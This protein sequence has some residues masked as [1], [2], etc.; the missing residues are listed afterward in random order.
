MV[1]PTTTF[2][3]LSFRGGRVVQECFSQP[4]VVLCAHLRWALGFWKPWMSE[5]VRAVGVSHT[6]GE[7][8]KLLPPSPVGKAATSSNKYEGDCRDEL[9]T[10]NEKHP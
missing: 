2:L 8:L 6:P 7:P 5:H 10:L 4:A 1:R 3:L 9:E